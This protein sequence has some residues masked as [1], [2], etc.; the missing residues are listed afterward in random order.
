MKTLKDTIEEMLTSPV[1][2]SLTHKYKNSID[3]SGW[4]IRKPKVV[5]H[6]TK[7]IESC[8]FILYQINNIKDVLKI[9]SYE[10]I[11]YITDLVRQLEKQDNIIFVATIGKVRHHYK[12]GDYTQVLEMKTIAELNMPLIEPYMPKGD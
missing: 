2:S 9:D 7:K 5:K 3:L 6:D 8:S 11:T 12:Y 4:I 10:C 1:L